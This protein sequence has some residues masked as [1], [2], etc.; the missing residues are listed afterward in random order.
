MAPLAQNTPPSG[1]AP[2]SDESWRHVLVPLIAAAALL[3]AVIGFLEVDA[4]A[5]AARAQRDARAATLRAVAKSSAAI[6]RYAYERDRL[7]AYQSLAAEWLIERDR[8]FAAVSGAEA[9]AHVRSAS[10]LFEALDAGR[11]MSSLLSPPY[12]DESTFAAD[13]VQF[14]VDYF[15]V[16]ALRASE[17]DEALRAQSAAWTSKATRYVVMLTVLAVSLFLFGLAAT[18]RGGL[19]RLFTAVGC[20]LDGA[21]IILIIVT[22]LAPIPVWSAE[23]VNDYA[24]AA[25]ELTYASSV[26]PLGQA[27]TAVDHASRAVALANEAIEERPDYAAAYELRAMARLVA[28]EEAPLFAGAA[29]YAAAVQDFERAVALGRDS[30]A[31]QDLRARALFFAGRAGDALDAERTAVGLSPEQRLRFGL[32]LAILL[33][34]ADQVDES[35][36]EAEAAFAWAEGHPLGSDPVTFREAVLILERLAFLD[37]P[38]RAAL[39]TR[40]KEAFVSLVHLGVTSPRPLVA[41]IGSLSFAAGAALPATTAFSKGTETVEMRFDAA[42][43]AVGDSL[44][45]VVRRDQVEQP[46]LGWAEIWAGPASEVVVRTLGASR[47]GKTVFDL[48]S[49]TYAI[50]AYVGGALAASGSFVVE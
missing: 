25:G 23:S 29:A 28:A 26:A 40:I 33:L 15:T 6:V 36:R 14:N 35:M 13:V 44:V 9:A 17:E 12:F 50:E 16:P 18:L 48:P 22:A 30:G 10:R 11:S 4:G 1:R 34:G 38:G 31:L 3:G 5:R 27:A 7:A 49:G 24:N 37:W 41:R 46:S 39:E 20:S 42:G 43:L 19:R 47:G 2:L 32:H 8:A 45:V 21:L